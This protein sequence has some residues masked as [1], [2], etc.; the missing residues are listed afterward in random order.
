M[1]LLQGENL[2]ELQE[3]I[4]VQAELLDLKSDIKGLVEGH[5]IESK[6][7]PKIG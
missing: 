6:L 3:T 5:I 2:T 1:T 7:H 4:A